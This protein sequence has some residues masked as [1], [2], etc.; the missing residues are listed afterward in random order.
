[1]WEKNTWFQG[2]QIQGNARKCHVLSNTDQYQQVKLHK[3][4]L[5]LVQ[6]QR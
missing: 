2:D 4:K 3:A 6:N 1:M 5:S